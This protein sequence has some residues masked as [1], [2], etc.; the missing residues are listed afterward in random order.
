MTGVVFDIQEF[1]IHDGPGIRV[2]VFLKGCPL[3]CAWCHNPEGQAVE[4]ELMVKEALCIHCGRCRVPCRHAACRPYARCLH[5]C[6]RGLIR[7]CGQRWEAAELTQRIESC[8]DLLQDGGVT[9]SGGEPLQQAA[10][11]AEVCDRLPGLHKTLQTSGCAEEPRFQALAGRMQYILFDLKLADPAAHTAYT[12]VGNDSILRNFD[13]LKTAGIPFA[14]RI[15]LIPGITDT[16]A[17]LTALA[18]MT[19]GCR[20]ELIPYNP[21]AGAKYSM[22]GRTYACETHTGNRVDTTLFD[23]AVILR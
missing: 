1:T 13:W 6:P 18:G 11:V 10:F 5:A 19:R 23:Q 9:F 2:T 4:P 16:P 14:V 22:I 3:R 20:V 12:G 21:L 17:N 8:A 15:P 7:E